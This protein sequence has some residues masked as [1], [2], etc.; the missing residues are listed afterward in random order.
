M[1][2]CVPAEWKIFSAVRRYRDTMFEISYSNPDGVQK[3]VKSITV[4]GK[5]ISGNTIGKEFLDGKTH[6]VAVVMGA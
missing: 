1:H 6:K 4:D 3:G 2:P 5:A